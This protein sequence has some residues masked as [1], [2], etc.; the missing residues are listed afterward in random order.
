[1]GRKSALLNFFIAFA[2]LA[3]GL[4]VAL[5]VSLSRDA[6]LPVALGVSIASLCCLIA[7]ELPALRSGHLFG[8]GPW[9]APSGRRWLWW[10]A[11]GL[12]VFPGFLAVVTVG[13]A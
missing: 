5:A 2:P 7:L 10:L 4:S 9:Q 1:M 3:V 8:F 13:A 11:L 6:R 12:L